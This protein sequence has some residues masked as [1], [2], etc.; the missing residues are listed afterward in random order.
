MGTVL[1]KLVEGANRG[2]SSDCL[3][4]SLFRSEDDAESVRSLD[5]PTSLGP[6]SGASS[7]TFAEAGARGGAR[8]LAKVEDVDLE[9]D[10]ET[11]LVPA[12][13]PAVTMLAGASSIA[14]AG[15]ADTFAS[16]APPLSTAERSSSG[17]AGLSVGTEPE[18]DGELVSS[19]VFFPVAE[20]PTLPAG[21]PSWRQEQSPAAASAVDDAA[22]C[23]PPVT[24]LEFLEA[25]CVVPAAVDSA[26]KRAAARRSKAQENAGSEAEDKPLLQRKRSLSPPALASSTSIGSSAELPAKHGRH[27]D[28][29]QEDATPGAAPAEKKKETAKKAGAKEK[30]KE[31]KAEKKS[32]G[33]AKA[34]GHS[35]EPYSEPAPQPPATPDKQKKVASPAKQASK[36]DP[37][38][39]RSPRPRR[40]PA[41]A[42]RALSAL[43]QAAVESSRSN[44]QPPSA[45]RRPSSRRR[46]GTRA[47]SALPPSPPSRALLPSP[48]PKREPS[49]VKPAARRDPS[50][51]R[52]PAKPAVESSPAK[53]P[54]PK[55]EPSPAK[56][57]ARRDPSAERSPA[58]PA[59]ESTPAKPPVPKREPS[60]V[61]PAAR[62]DPSAERSPAAAS[63]AAASPA[64]RRQRE[65]DEAAAEEVPP[66]REPP[67]QKQ[68]VDAEPE[69]AAAE[70]AGPDAMAGRVSP[71]PHPEDLPARRL[72]RAALAHTAA[73]QLPA[74]AR[75]APRRRRR[76]RR[77]GRTRR[78]AAGA[79][80]ERGPALLMPTVASA[81]GRSLGSVDELLG[82]GL[83]EDERRM[84]S[85]GDPFAASG[86]TI[87]RTTLS[88]PPEDLFGVEEP[89]VW[90]PSD[91][92]PPLLRSESPPPPAEAGLEDDLSGG[93]TADDE[94]FIRESCGSTELQGALLQARDDDDEGPP[95]THTD[96]EDDLSAPLTEAD[97]APLASAGM[98]YYPSGPASV[99][100]ASVCSNT[101]LLDMR[102]SLELSSAGGSGACTPM[103]A[104]GWAPVPIGE[105][106]AT[107][108]AA[109]GAGAAATVARAGRRIAVPRGP[110][111]LLPLPM[112]PRASRPPRLPHPHLLP[113]RPAPAAARPA[114][115]PPAGSPRP[116]ARPRGGGLARAPL[117][118][119]TPA[120]TPAKKE[121]TR[122]AGAAPPAPS[123]PPAP[124][125]PP[126]CRRPQHARRRAA[127]RRRPR[128]ASDAVW[129]RQGGARRDAG[130]PH[131]APLLQALAPAPHAHRESM[132]LR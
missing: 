126:P 46:G 110:P 11:V 113:A 50:A 45:S 118:G 19:S 92:P 37:S 117:A 105:A 13:A 121:A 90:R 120:A 23:I 93:L 56:P 115:A 65:S 106:A 108:F 87:V 51:E 84:L 5:E 103:Y 122:P 28:T 38:A 80:G 82:S 99:A 52:S 86:R 53:P 3:C 104:D 47:P 85:S 42:I 111:P 1:S 101:P 60:P 72:A 44:L 55:R 25:A 69:R 62:R 131:P 81:S 15:S 33:A 123:T 34:A 71:G 48:G 43:R 124:P 20:S 24:S 116:R 30:E 26:K 41:S 39:E 129:G 74:P 83:T 97:M 107:A 29:A 130:E 79:D 40:P 4:C 112:S 18:K 89:G 54:V 35:F 114:L 67:P 94:R 109:V 77:P 78:A 10:A 32:A 66:T 21:P 2:G 91:G 14:A 27:Q 9:L 102:R 63:A 64:K 16:S 75:P 7:P 49:P 36:R 88:P 128:N 6:L 96:D 58:K 76:L 22:R 61:K 57:A 73:A 127:R 68:R 12:A 70:P 125:P 59:V 98:G 31:K 119:R 8:A 17:R 132:P 100:T 95:P